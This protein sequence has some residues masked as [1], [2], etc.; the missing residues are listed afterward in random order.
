MWTAAM[1]RVLSLEEEQGGGTTLVAMA[2]GVLSCS[3][4]R[5]IQPVVCRSHQSASR[6]PTPWT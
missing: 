1:A 4:G 2:S 3:G 5:A 6:G